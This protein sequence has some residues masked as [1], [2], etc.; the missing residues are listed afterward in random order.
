VAPA[1]RSATATVSAPAPASSS[2]AVGE[3]EG[4]FPWGALAGDTE[5]PSARVDTDR[6]PDAVQARP[7]VAHGEQRARTREKSTN[8]LIVGLMA[9]AAVL[10]VLVGGT[11]WAG[12]FIYTT[13]F[14]TPAAQGPPKLIVSAQDA[15]K[16]GVYKTITAA[17]RVAPRESIIELA[18]E[19]IEENVLWEYSPRN[20]TEV[21]IQAAPGTTV[22]WKAARKDPREPILRL[23][24][25]QNFK[26]KGEGII[27]DGDLGPKGKVKD[28]VLIMGSSEGL[29]IEDAQFKN[30]GRSGIAVVSAAGTLESP[31]RLTG[32]TALSPPAEKDGVL[33]WIDAR[34]DMRLKQVDFIEITDWRAPGLTKEQVYRAE[35][36]AVGGG[37]SNLPR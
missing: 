24:S 22:T 6:Q 19:V 17:L 16:S 21:T 20:N 29:T 15:G 36:G 11:I 37:Y 35:N 14:V 1:S 23:T 26:I 30:Y 31:I 9:A 2:P 4:E 32:I 3:P 34:P 7:A 28:L 12:W 18:D 8:L 27:F 10:V 5:D 13:F 25:G 33:M